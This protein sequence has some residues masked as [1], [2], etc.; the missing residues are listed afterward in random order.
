MAAELSRVTLQDFAPGT[1]TVIEFD[2]ESKQDA[3]IELASVKAALARGRF[4]WID[5]FAS[6]P[7]LVRAV[8]EELPGCDASWIEAVSKDEPVTQHARFE[9][10]LHVS[11]CALK[12]SSDFEIERVD[13][14]LSEHVLVT[15]RRGP[16][17]FLDTL[18]KTYRFDF[19]SFAKTPSFLLYEIWDQLLD[20]YLVAQKLLEE[21]VERAQ[22]ELRADQVGDEVFRT[23]AELSAD[24]LRFRKVLLPA[25]AVLSDL[26]TRRSLVISEITQRH[27]GNLI[28]PLEHILGDL[29][30][31]AEL[32]SESLNLYMSLVAHRTN[33]V[34]KRLTAVSVVFMPLTF[35]VGIYG[36]NFD[37]FPELHWR[38][39][40]AYFWLFVACLV[41]ALLW[42]MRRTR[43]I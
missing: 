18:H 22:A 10:A 34:M 9:R 26:A 24:L 8:L 30:V 19:V 36:M 31:D 41:A 39:G 38:Y 21:R 2:F 42:L 23:V 33:E 11:I 40:Y 35:V 13:L 27:L 1:V 29:L 28:G 12:R 6:T 7:E 32:L 17:E 3:W 37:V 20:S 16:V 25:R 43:L 5:L 4:V 14:M 15:L